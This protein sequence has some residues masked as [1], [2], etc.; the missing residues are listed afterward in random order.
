MFKPDRG[1]GSTHNYELLREKIEIGEVN[2]YL[3]NGRKKCFD[4]RLEFKLT[5]DL[6]AWL[7][8]EANRTGQSM[9]A[10]L[11]GLMVREVLRATPKPSVRKSREEDDLSF[12]EALTLE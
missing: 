8:A 6:R 5:S 10:Y 2:P 1:R 3:F 7:E 12:L 11:R 9:S 4:E